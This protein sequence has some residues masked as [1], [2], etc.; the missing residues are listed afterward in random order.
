VLGGVALL[1]DLGVDAAQHVAG[2]DLLQGP[3][4]ALVLDGF[5]VVDLIGGGNID[6]VH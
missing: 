2:V 3:R 4:D 1:G 5:V 6:V